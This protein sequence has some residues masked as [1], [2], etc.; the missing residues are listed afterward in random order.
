M[1]RRYAVMKNAAISLVFGLLALAGLSCTNNSSGP[2]VAQINAN[3]RQVSGCIS[4]VSSSSQAG[5]S[6]F[7]YEFG[8]TLYVSFMLSGNCCPDSNR[9]SLSYEVRSDT[10]YVAATDTAARMCYCICNYVLRAE[11]ANLPFD[12]YT[13]ICTRP[14]DGGKVY[15]DEIVVRKH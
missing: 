7:A 8:D 4:K 10:L 11:F 13:F 5:D 12:R 1:K 3:L 9:F 2:G 15:Y 14:D 6:S